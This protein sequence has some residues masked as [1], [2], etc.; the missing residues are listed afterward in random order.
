MFYLTRASKNDW[1]YLQLPLLSLL[2]PFPFHMLIW[3]LLIPSLM[4][5]VAV[6]LT[7]ILIIIVGALAALGFFHYRRTGSLLPSLPKLPRSVSL[8]EILILEAWVIF[9]FFFFKLK[10]HSM[11]LT[12]SAETKSDELKAFISNHNFVIKCFFFEA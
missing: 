2:V 1:P 7:I 9:F 8:W 3:S 6:L 5:A 4:A 11:Q 10:K 12:F